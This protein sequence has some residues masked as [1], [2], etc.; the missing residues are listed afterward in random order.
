MTSVC[1]HQLVRRLVVPKYTTILRAVG[2]KS[3]FL[4]ENNKTNELHKGVDRNN[5]KVM[6][7]LRI[8]YR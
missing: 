8:V 6:K 5:I 3:S 1:K 2:K 7:G 4:F